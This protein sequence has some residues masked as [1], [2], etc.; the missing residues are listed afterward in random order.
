MKILDIQG[1]QSTPMVK[2]DPSTG[3]LFMKG[4]LI[5]DDPISF[6]GL[7][8]DWL[9]NYLENPAEK[10]TFYIA[11]EYINT[12]GLKTLVKFLKRLEG[13]HSKLTHVQAIWNV[14]N[15]D[16]YILEIAQDVK[17]V[18]EIPIEIVCQN[19]DEF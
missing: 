5:T 6:F 11:F 14:V 12:G 2:F 18:V 17:T 4:R 13:N 16:E 19:S 1:T 8:E 15:D 10:T 9:S 7:L 3:E